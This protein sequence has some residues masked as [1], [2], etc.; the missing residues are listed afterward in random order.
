MYI[1]KTKKTEKGANKAGKN[2]GKK[3]AGGGSKATNKYKSSQRRAVAVEPKP[4]KTPA[5]PRTRG[6]PTRR[7]TK[8]NH[9]SQR[10]LSL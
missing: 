10:L 8:M 5:A 4:R 7:K 1:I 2:K 9:A 6:T 3:P